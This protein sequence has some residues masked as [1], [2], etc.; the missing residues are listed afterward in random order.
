MSA[1]LSTRASISSLALLG[2]HQ[3]ERHVVAHRHVRIQRV[4][5]EHHRD[6]ALLR[7][8]AVDDLAAD[9]DFAVGDFLEARDH[10]QQRRLAAAGRADQHAE[11]AVGNV[12]V[13]AA[14]HLR[15]AE[16]LLH[17]LDAY[18]C[19]LPPSPQLSA[20]ASANGYSRSRRVPF[21]DDIIGPPGLDP[22]HDVLCRLAP[23]LD[24]G[25]HAEERGVRRQDHFGVAE[26][27]R[28]PQRAR[29]AGRRVQRRQVF[30]YRVR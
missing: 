4:V 3:R 2:Q 23:Q 30:H 10:A 17:C 28:Y 6:V 13:D 25:L 21:D 27:P 15:R 24:L 29:P 1:A 26:Q 11:L 22:G 19:H 9:A 12:D 8:H 7:R 18:R 16:V 20:A 14:N 5:L